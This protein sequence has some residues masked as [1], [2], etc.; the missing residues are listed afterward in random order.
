MEILSLFMGSVVSL[1]IGV[2]TVKAFLFYRICS[3]YEKVGDYIKFD[4]EV[5]ALHDEKKKAIKGKLVTVSFPRYTAT[6][7]EQEVN[8]LS[9]VKRLSVSIGGN[10]ELYRN[11]NSGFVWAKGDINILKKDIAVRITMIIILAVVVLAVAL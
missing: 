11:N 9:V 1:Y 3:R 10:V 4:G 8:Y 7:D 5:T 2:L 6:I